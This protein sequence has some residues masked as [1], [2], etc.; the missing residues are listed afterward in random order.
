MSTTSQRKICC[1]TC[2][3]AVSLDDKLWFYHNHIFCDPKCQKVYIKSILNH[4]PL[5]SGDRY[6]EDV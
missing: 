2:R 1:F 3:K 4:I 5:D 6:D